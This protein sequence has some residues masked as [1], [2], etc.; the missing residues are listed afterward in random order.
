MLPG[1]I[2]TRSA[3]PGILLGRCCLL[4]CVWRCVK[5][6]WVRFSLNSFSIYWFIESNQSNAFM[7]IYTSVNCWSLVSIFLHFN[8]VEWIDPKP[9]FFISR[10]LCLPVCRLETHVI[11]ATVITN[12]DRVRDAPC[13]APGMPAPSVEM[14]GPTRSCTPTSVSCQFSSSKIDP[15]IDWLLLFLLLKPVLFNVSNVGQ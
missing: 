13:R 14:S 2:S 6:M 9:M 1:W 12:T 3:F 11:V 15:S 4:I 7:Y 8:F 10:V 5:E